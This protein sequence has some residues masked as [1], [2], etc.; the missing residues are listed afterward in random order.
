MDIRL[1]NLILYFNSSNPISISTSSHVGQVLIRKDIK[2]F[3]Q[4]LHGNFYFLKPVANNKIVVFS[5]GIYFN[6]K[7]NWVFKDFGG[8]DPLR[9]NG[10]K[11]IPITVVVRSQKNMIN[12]DN[13]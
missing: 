8:M 12:H 11:R 10:K 9:S 3:A 6:W 5:I 7:K 1:K 4:I 2:N 13:F